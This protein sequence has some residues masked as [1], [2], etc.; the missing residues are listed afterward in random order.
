MAGCALRNHPMTG[1]SMAGHSVLNYVW[2][3]YRRL[4][5]ALHTIMG[6]LYYSILVFTFT[7]TAR[8]APSPSAQ[9]THVAHSLNPSR[10]SSLR[11][12][13]LPCH[14]SQPSWERGTMAAASRR[15]M[16][17]PSSSATWS[18]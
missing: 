4:Y 18:Q 11:R 2:S 17:D 8:P 13:R 15:P 1:Y 12:P 14:H 6:R 3:A 16:S 10:S 9:A 5:E 7:P